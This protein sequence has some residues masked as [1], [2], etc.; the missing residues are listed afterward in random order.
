[1]TTE[2]IKETEQIEETVDN[3]VEETIEDEKV[4]EE[5]KPEKKLSKSD[6]RKCFAIWYTTSESCLS[7]ERLMSMG[8]CHAMTPIINKLYAD[9]KEERVKAL[10]RH[11]LFFNTENNWGAFIPG[12]VC[13]MEEDYANGGNVTEDMIKNVKVGL[14]GPLAGI[15]DT[16]TQGLVRTVLLSIAV[17]MALQG[18]GIAPWLFLLI[19]GAYLIL[20][21]RFAFK[22]GYYT[23]RDVLGEITD[24]R[25]VQKI[26]N[27]LS[28]VGLTVAG[29]MIATFVNVETPLVI[30]LD[31]S[32]VVMQEL[33]D[34]IIPGFLG[35]V[36]TLGVFQALNRGKKVN[37]ILI[38]LVVIAIVCSFIG[39][40]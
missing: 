3:K 13:S 39:F 34:A 18:N 31:Q 27:V 20:M 7:Y 12:L 32:T 8:F 2:N 10:R 1:M 21:G 5:N 19:Y 16:I 4:V 23:G 33:F 9:D 15:G 36:T 30:T 24:G 6:L 37:H 22:K 26:T 25:V 38:T 40:L 35:L 14:M 29:A 11:M 28:L 17:D